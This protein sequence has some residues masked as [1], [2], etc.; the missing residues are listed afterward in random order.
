MFSLSGINFY[1][2]QMNAGIKYFRLCNISKQL[3]LPPLTNKKNY[4]SRTTMT[5]HC[6]ALVKAP[7][8][9]Q[10]P[11]RQFTTQFGFMLHRFWLFCFRWVSA[12]LIVLSSLVPKQHKLLL[13]NLYCYYTGLIVVCVGGAADT[14]GLCLFGSCFPLSLSL[15]HSR[16]HNNKTATYIP[17]LCSV[18][19]F[20]AV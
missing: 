12:S 14:N 11:G 19:S 13:F 9:M 18:G 4:L 15:S 2:V 5:D 16:T 3:I 1:H 10:P 17:L 8:A 6:Q 20:T 7:V